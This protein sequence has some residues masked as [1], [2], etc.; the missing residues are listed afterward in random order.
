M[1]ILH[2]KD[3]S[4]HCARKTNY[5]IVVIRLFVCMGLLA[6][7]LQGGSR[8][9]TAFPLMNDGITDS[10]LVATTGGIGLAIDRYAHVKV[11]GD[12]FPASPAKTFYSD[13]IS[14]GR[15]TF[16]YYYVDTGLGGVYKRNAILGPSAIAQLGSAQRVCTISAPQDC[17]LHVNNGDHGVL[18]SFIQRGTLF[19]RYLQV[20]NGNHWANIDS[21]ES[22]G[23][24]FSGQC[25]LAT[26]T[27][28]VINTVDMKRAILRKVYSNGA[29]LIVT[30][31]VTVASG[32]AT[33]GN[34]L[35]NCSV[36]ADGSG[37]ILAT[38]IRGS[39]NNSKF[40]Y[41]QFYTS[42][43]TPIAGGMFTNK[44]SN[45]KFYYYEDVPVVSYGAGKFALVSWDS[46]GVVLHQLELS[47]LVI[48][49]KTTRILTNPVL[50]PVA[51]R[52]ITIIW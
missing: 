45:N 42:N 28:L 14:S 43:F 51:L 27:F 52:Q 24:I 6:G 40:C 5:P 3:T 13:V 2:N 44:V 46:A 12:S 16:S 48:T 36:A 15:D 11:F 41:Y 23:W 20:H 19:K 47:G 32:S 34:S 4:E 21:A 25:H 10:N 38:A 29:S 7:A 22:S 17:Y 33:Q 35:M 31:T 50:S 37:I 30:D 49:E 1:M 39:P 18:C 8:K 9:Q 26:D